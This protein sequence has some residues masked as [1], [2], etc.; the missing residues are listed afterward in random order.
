MLFRCFHFRSNR[1]VFF[2]LRRFR[3]SAYRD[4]QKRIVKS[5]IT[6]DRS[7]LRGSFHRHGDGWIA[8]GIESYRIIRRHID[9]ANVRD[10]HQ[11]NTSDV[12]QTHTCL[13]AADWCRCRQATQSSTACCP[14]ITRIVRR[15]VCD[16]N[17]TNK[18]PG[19][20]KKARGVV[21]TSAHRVGHRRRRRIVLRSNCDRINDVSVGDVTSDTAGGGG[22]CEMCCRVDRNGVAMRQFESRAL[23]CVR[24]V[25]MAQRSDV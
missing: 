22:A 8:I 4:R 15:V 17:V 23:L 2:L 13:R 18:R 19:D 12:K 20:S 7:I 9:S 11:R 21:R 5:K 25:P 1:R 14:L 16:V 3:L 6:T 10:K 24:N